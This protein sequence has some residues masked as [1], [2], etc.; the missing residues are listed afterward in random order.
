LAQ[1]QADTDCAAQPIN[2]ASLKFF[3]PLQ[4]LSDRMLSEVMEKGQVLHYSAH[5]RLLIEGRMSRYSVF[6]LAGELRFDAPSGESTLIISGTDSARHCLCD[7][8]DKDTMLTSLNDVQLLRINKAFLE[9]LT[10]ESHSLGKIEVEELTADDPLY[11]NRLMF[12]IC[13]QYLS[14]DLAIPSLPG[15]AL[16]VRKAVLDP[17]IA[18][19]DV[20]ILVQSD[21]AIAS[22]LIQ[23]TNSVLNRGVV[24]VSDCQAAVARLG[25]NTTR[26]LVT[27]FA[28]HSL[29]RA[30]TP[31]VKKRMLELWK[32]ST[33]V[34]AI[35]A[36]IARSVPHLNPDRALLAGLTHDIGVLVLLAQIDELGTDKFDPDLVDATLTTLRAQ[37]G[38]MVLRKWKLGDDLVEVA[39]ESDEWMR[40]Q[41]KIDYCDVVLV[42]QLH[43]FVGTPEQKLYPRLV[44]V[45]AFKKLPL[46]NK[47]PKESL[48]VLCRA[49]KDIAQM[50]QLLMGR[51]G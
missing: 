28:I 10:G 33:T 47:G 34:A 9:K 43:S 23:A 39:L 24:A 16:R 3:Q 37:V 48:Q 40:T 17:E 8:S 19:A 1:N 38:A 31:S 29:F 21:P 22:G 36:V 15:L 46:S 27:S 14:D 42:A 4:S 11:E 18:L 20:A 7:A 32:H 41:K 49:K 45:P 51:K 6:L 30:K 50:R 35:S 2:P 25:L 5:R 44:D 13:H 12:D 26:D